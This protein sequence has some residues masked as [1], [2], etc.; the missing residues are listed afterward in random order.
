MDMLVVGLNGKGSVPGTGATFSEYRTQ[1]SMWSMLCSP[2]M[3]GCDIRSMDAQIASLLMNREVLALNQDA[4]GKQAVRVI[5]RG[6][7]EIWKKPLADG[8]LALA[9]LNR[10]SSSAVIYFKAGEVGLLDSPRGPVRD[11]WKQADVA[12]LILGYTQKVEPHAT[13]LLKI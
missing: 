1:M 2:L 6:P 10:G 3:I 4:L 7:L 5:Q 8:S 12:D 9:L 11:L 13:V